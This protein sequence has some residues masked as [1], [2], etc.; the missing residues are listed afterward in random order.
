MLCM[1]D[2]VPLLAALSIIVSQTLVLAL[3]LRIFGLLFW[4]AVGVSSASANKAILVC[5]QLKV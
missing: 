5:L 4:V 1:R 3:H 2:F